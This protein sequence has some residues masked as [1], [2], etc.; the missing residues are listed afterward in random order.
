MCTIAGILLIGPLG[1]NFSETLIG[2]QTF[3][4]KKMHLK[5]SSA[6]W[7]LFCLCLNVLN[8]HSSQWNNPH[9]TKITFLLSSMMGVINWYKS[10]RSH[11]TAGV[12]RQISPYQDIM[13]INQDKIYMLPITNWYNLTKGVILPWVSSFFLSSMNKSTLCSK[14]WSSSYTG[15]PRHQRMSEPCHQHALPLTQANTS[16]G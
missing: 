2:I 6:K 5:M 14:P 7:R 3:L 4:F 15:V 16:M 10:T 13:L 11:S 8:C 9:Y 1:T 12:V